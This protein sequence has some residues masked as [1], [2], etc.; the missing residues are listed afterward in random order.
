[1]KNLNLVT[2]MEI[3]LLDNN[4]IPCESA[5][6]MDVIDDGLIIEQNGE[7]SILLDLN[8]IIVDYFINYKFQPIE[9]SNL[10]ETYDLETLDYTECEE[11]LTKCNE[12]GFTFE[13]DLDG[14]PINLTRI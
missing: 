5:M 1:M 10:L 6:I 2:G 9:L 13:Y 11:L 8:N 14:C 7:M 12:L 3:S 4:G